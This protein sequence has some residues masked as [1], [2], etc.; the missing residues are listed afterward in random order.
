MFWAIHARDICLEHSLQLAGVEMP[1]TAL[2]VVIDAAG[3]T[4]GRARERHPGL[5]HHHHDHLTVGKT[6][7]DIVDFPWGRKAEDL[8]VEFAIAHA[9]ACQENRPGRATRPTRN[10]DAPK[11]KITVERDGTA[12]LLGPQW[13][14]V[15]F[16]LNHINH[17]H[18]R[19]GE[20]PHLFQVEFGGVHNMAGLDQVMGE[21]MTIESITIVIPVA[22][23]VST[24]PV[25]TVA[26]RSA[27]PIVFNF[28]SVS[29]TPRKR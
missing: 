14:E 15:V 9:R 23:S 26:I 10:P 25:A 3:T 27:K 28:Y 11:K 18:Y 20:G 17:R 2:A 24:P 19:D 7:T 5:M 8:L 21:S 4:A 12:E 6:Q 29:V 22:P 16:Y 1:P 13:P